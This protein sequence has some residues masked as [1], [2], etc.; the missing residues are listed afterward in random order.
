VISST[1]RIYVRAALL[2]LATL[3]SAAMAQAQTS[4]PAPYLH[5]HPIHSAKPAEVRKR[6]VP[7]VSSHR[8]GSPR[9]PPHPVAAATPPVA[10]TLVAKQVPKKPLPPHLP[11][12]VGPN[13]GL[14][15]PRYAALKSDEVNM[16]SGPG[17]RYPVLWTYQRRD[18]PVKI[19]HEFDIWRQVEDM[20]GIK[21]WMQ[22][23]FLVGHRS[24][25]TI[26]SEDHVLRSD[27]A[28]SSEPIAILKPGVVGRIRSCEAGKE[29]C[30]V[31]VQ[32]YRGWL[33]R[34]DF[35]GTD[36]GEAI[37]P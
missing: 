34:S 30:Q 20:D 21:G 13:S 3:A 35:W 9:R 4:D 33:K 22:E 18:L 7:V 10:A 14:K 6:R 29:W 15:L 11:P 19:E 31:Q 2:A 24:F 8:T 25:V 32:D 5:T 26:G 1:I 16:R 37:G 36:P 28:D 17:E 23:G 27:A 12:D